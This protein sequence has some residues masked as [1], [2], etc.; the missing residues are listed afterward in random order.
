MKKKLEILL[1]NDDSF[2]AKGFRTLVTLCSAVG[3]VTCFAPRT[4][5]SGKSAALSMEIPLYLKEEETKT[6]ANGT[7]SSPETASLIFL[8]PV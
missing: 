2:T 6:A 4:P 5:Q 3:N 7:L 8:S 1:T